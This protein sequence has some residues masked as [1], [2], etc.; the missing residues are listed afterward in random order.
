MVACRRSSENTSKMNLIPSL[1][2][3]SQHAH[4][5]FELDMLGVPRKLVKYVVHSSKSKNWKNIFFFTQATQST[6]F[7]SQGIL[8]VKNRMAIKS[9]HQV[10]YYHNK[11]LN[12]VKCWEISMSLSKCTNQCDTIWIL[13]NWSAPCATTVFTRPHDRS[14]LYIILG[15]KESTP[16]LKRTTFTIPRLILQFTSHW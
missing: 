3:T 7:L 10:F 12:S 8:G 9:L 11:Y 5:E 14:L 6:G 4:M 1:K 16:V 15:L 13:S 2:K